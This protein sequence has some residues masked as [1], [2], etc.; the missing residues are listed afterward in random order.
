MLLS[1]FIELMLC[2]VKVVSV[3]A[4]SSTALVSYCELKEFEMTRLLTLTVGICS[5][6]YVV[7]HGAP[8]NFSK[9]KSVKY[10]KDPFVQC[11]AFEQGGVMVC[12]SSYDDSKPVI[13]GCDSGTCAQYCDS[14]GT[15]ECTQSRRCVKKPGTGS[16][17]N[18]PL[19][20]EDA[21]GNGPPE[22][23]TK[24]ITAACDDECGGS[25]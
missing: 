25:D 24:Y 15:T 23:T 12:P 14:D 13:P 11:V 9:P 4:V 22:W 16:E 3:S 18:T 20:C 19:L 2:S 17:N 1:P 21:G 10:C 7:A 5:L 8:C 6:L